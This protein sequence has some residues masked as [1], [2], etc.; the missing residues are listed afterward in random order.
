MDDT[1]MK[2]LLLVFALLFVPSTA[3]AQCNG[4]FPPNT[5]CGNPTTVPAVPSVQSGFALFVKDYGAVCDFATNDT[6]AQQ[7]AINQGVALG[8]AVRYTGTRLCVTTAPLTVSGVVDIGGTG[9]YGPGIFC[10][11]CGIAIKI[12]WWLQVNIHDLGIGNAVSPNTDT[13]I[14]LDCD[15]SCTAI[16]GGHENT[17]SYFSNI[18]ISGFLNG[19]HALKAEMWML[20]HSIING[21]QSGG[22]PI[23]V[24][25]QFNTDHGDS[26]IDGNLI[27]G[28]N[29][30][31][32]YQTSSGGLRIENNKILCSNCNRGYYMN[33]CS[34]CNTGDLFIV[35]NSFEGVDLAGADD[36]RFVRAGTT[37][38]FGTI[39]IIGNELSSGGNCVTVPLDANGPWLTGLTIVGNIC[40][41]GGTSS[42]GFSIAS[43][44]GFVVA[45]N[46]VEGNATTNFSSKIDASATSCFIGPNP[47]IGVFTPS[48]T[49]AC[50][51]L[52][53]F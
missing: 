53:P 14:T 39:T 32:I 33:L 49:A 46:V 47:I 10:N 21:T 13:G 27:Q 7:N 17:S 41:I 45:N 16:S 26:E 30:P 48:T 50:A 1:D 23:W 3:W 4:V 2:K 40:G 36:I 18:L 6:V 25:N 52:A 31:A 28:N 37:G 44:T 19:F 42:T 34:G 29:G 51:T 24:E 9:A 5:V 20:T 12:N 22:R 15:A 43:T 11:A 38:G 8:V 35:G